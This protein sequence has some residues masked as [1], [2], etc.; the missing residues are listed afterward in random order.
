MH[1]PWSLCILYTTYHDLH[2]KVMAQSMVIRSFVRSSVIHIDGLTHLVMLVT[3]LTASIWL[4]TLT[5][6]ANTWLTT[7]SNRTMRYKQTNWAYKILYKIAKFHCMYLKFH[8]ANSAGNFTWYSLKCLCHC[9]EISKWYDEPLLCCHR[10]K[11]M[12]FCNEQT[13]T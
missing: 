11:N 9:R 8:H 10:V 12:Q 4:S 3:A 6:V 7:L 2:I 5:S 1:I 13:R